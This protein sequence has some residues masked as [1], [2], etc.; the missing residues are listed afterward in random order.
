MRPLTTPKA[1]QYPPSRNII[2]YVDDNNPFEH[3]HRREVAISMFQDDELV[4]R[5]L[6]SRGQFSF[7][8]NRRYLHEMDIEPLFFMVLDSILESCKP[9][10]TKFQ[11]TRT[12]AVVYYHA[13]PATPL[14]GYQMLQGMGE[15]KYVLLYDTLRARDFSEVTRI[16]CPHRG[17]WGSRFIISPFYRPIMT[18]EKEDPSDSFRHGTRLYVGATKERPAPPEQWV[19]EEV[20]YTS[21]W[22]TALSHAQQ[23]RPE[24]PATYHVDAGTDTTT[25]SNYSNYDTRG[26]NT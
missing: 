12:A 4:V 2:W 22:D 3:K 23:T 1:R 18:D 26:T 17:P 19:L 6:Y 25:S 11:Y 24:R 10:R 15:D 20:S 14:P 7:E 8:H 16:V 5:R 21:A 9:T 13:P